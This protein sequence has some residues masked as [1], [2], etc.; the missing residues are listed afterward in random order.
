MAVLIGFFDYVFGP[1]LSLG[2]VWT[3]VGISLLLSII[4]TLAT[5]FL[6]NQE[7]MK[8]LK[9][10]ITELQKKMKEQS[11]DPAKMMGFQKEA[12]QKNL[13]YMKHSFR[14]TL[15]TILPLLLIF[16]WLQSHFGTLGKL[17]FI[18]VVGWGVGWIGTYILSSIVFTILLRK[19]FKV[20]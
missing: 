11:Q 14:A 16:G 19:L 8:L 13:Q 3:I 18:P 1:L 6:T 4:V 7:T 15:Y 5:K 20:F 2:P 10:E 17:W 9:G 12:M